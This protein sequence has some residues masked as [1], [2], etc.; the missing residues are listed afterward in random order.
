MSYPVYEVDDEQA[1]AIINKEEDYLNDVKAIEIK[2]AKLSETVSAFS[3]AIGGDIYIGVDEDKT[4]QTRSW[5]GFNTPEDANAVA[6]VLLECHNLGNH[7][8]FE[9]LTCKSYTGYLLHITV[10]KVKEIVKSTS[11]DVYLRVNAGKIKLDTQEKIKRL[12]FDKGI[13]TFENEW[14]E[15]PLERVEN[16]ESIINFMINV[17]PTGE[18]RKYLENQ[19]LIKDKYSRVS[20]ILLF[21]DEPAVF[22]PKRSSIK[23]M[24]YK[25]KQEGISR[26]HLSGTPLTVEGDVYTQIYDAVEQ[27]KKIIEESKRLGAE[28]LEDVQYPDETLHEVITNAVLHRDYSITA[29]TQIRIFDNRVEIESPG[30]L[31]GHV[32]IENILDTQSA[33]N[34]QIV[35]LINKFPDPPNK[36]VGEGLNTAFEAMKNLKL[37]PPEISEEE[38]SVIVRIRHEPL[39][40]AEELVLQYLQ[41]YEEINNATG[42]EITGIKDSNQMKDVFIRLK[43]L[44]QLERVPEK[45][46]TAS[47]WRK[48]Q[49]GA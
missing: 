32:T 46:S 43:D 44:G 18:P 4:N 8:A 2:P 15:C 34:P 48:P 10:K 31:P 16:S 12:E 17:I 30:R 49:G 6:Q 38:N 45:R 9:F 5:R 33:R 40:S 11:G 39:A 3:N 37:K 42:R 7:L 20:G 47:A 19:D 23:I 26:E 21:C 1:N 14:V 29:D 35:R 24:R 36:D 13:V 28:G 27:T 41:N 25:T 22:L